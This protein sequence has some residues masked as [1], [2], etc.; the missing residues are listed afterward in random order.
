LLLADNASLE[1]RD[2]RLAEQLRDVSA[3]VWAL[4][5]VAA[6]TGVFAG[7]SMATGQW[8]AYGVSALSSV[9]L[10]VMGLPVVGG[11]MHWWPILI[12]PALFAL[13]FARRFW[14]V[15]SFRRR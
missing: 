7:V 6:G 11:H 5:G 10:L 8:W 9:F 12:I 3:A 15:G 4:I 13:Y 2:P 14:Q 1:E